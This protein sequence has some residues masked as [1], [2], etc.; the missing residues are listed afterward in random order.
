MEELHRIVRA[1]MGHDI[2]FGYPHVLRVM[3]NAAFLAEAKGANKILVK[4]A[5]LLHD[6]AFDGKNIVTHAE[7]SAVR[8]SEVLKQLN[9]SADRRQAIANMIR[10]HDFRVWEKEGMPSTLE[11]KIISDA[12]N[13][14]RCSPQG[15]IKFIILASKLP[16]YRDSSD[17]LHSASK[18]INKAF[19]SLFFEESRSRAREN[20][21]L[22][23]AFMETLA[24]NIS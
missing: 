5:A 24:K 12:E 3:D 1:K 20:Y 18:F 23:K 7:E 8:A 21:N 2:L 10:K 22:A 19:G 11:E 13:I 14:E 15:M 17:I 9:V 6:I 16:A 4:M